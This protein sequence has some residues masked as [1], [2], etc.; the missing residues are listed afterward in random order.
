M[1]RTTKRDQCLVAKM[2]L[3]STPTTHNVTVTTSQVTLTETKHEKHANTQ[4]K[5]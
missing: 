3:Y 4:K 5:R 2:K 1:T